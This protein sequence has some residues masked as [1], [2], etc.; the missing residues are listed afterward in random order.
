MAV[1]L[2]V[3]V[4]ASAAKQ[5]GRDTMRQKLSNGCYLLNQDDFTS[6]PESTLFGRVSKYNGAI[7]TEAEAQLILSGKK[8]P[9]TIEGAT[10]EEHASPE[11]NE[12][13]DKEVESE[14]TEEEE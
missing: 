4:S 8:E 5:L 2:Y 13:L 3:I 7:I 1:Y 10:D 9:P 6:E 14:L 11:A 12:E